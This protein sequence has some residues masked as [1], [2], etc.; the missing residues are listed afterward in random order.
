[1]YVTIT[2]VTLLWLF[3]AKKGDE[4]LI[5]D[6]NGHNLALYRRILVNC[7]NINYHMTMI[8]LYDENY[9]I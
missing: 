3:R 7:I 2:S 8:Q 4:L 1:M 5:N 9:F 6:K